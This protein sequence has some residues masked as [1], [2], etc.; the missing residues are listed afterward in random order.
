MAKAHG[1][2][3]SLQQTRR[4]SLSVCTDSPSMQNGIL[5]L[6]IDIRKIQ[7]ADTNFLTGTSRVSIDAACL[8]RKREPTNTN[9]LRLTMQQRD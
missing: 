9:I 1:A 8:P 5:G 6:M 4:I 3:I 2:N 7:N